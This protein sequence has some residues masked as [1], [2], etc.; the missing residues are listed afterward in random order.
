MRQAA[1]SARM[2]QKAADAK[3]DVRQLKSEVDLV[4]AQLY[5]DEENTG[6]V[7]AKK[8][9]VILQNAYQAKDKLLRDALYVDDS[10]QA[11]VRALEHKRDALMNLGANARHEMDPELRTLAE[12]VKKRFK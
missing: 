2:A 8:Q 3:R 1:L 7:E 11:V 4:Y 6:S 12:H 9:W 5:N 10:M